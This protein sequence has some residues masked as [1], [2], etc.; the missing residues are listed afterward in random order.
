M[1]SFFFAKISDKYIYVHVI[2][3]RHGRHNIQNGIVWVQTG[4]STCTCTVS[5]HVVE[6]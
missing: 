5:L 3:N 1:I 6:L 4:Q 2:M